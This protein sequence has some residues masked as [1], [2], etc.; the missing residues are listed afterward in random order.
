MNFGY[1]VLFFTN[2]CHT[3]NKLNKLEVFTAII[4]FLKRTT[5]QS[6]IIKRTTFQSLITS[7]KIFFKKIQKYKMLTI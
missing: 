1:T 6:L 4:F 5:F 3:P 2:F 7:Y